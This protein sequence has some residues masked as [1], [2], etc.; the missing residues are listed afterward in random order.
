MLRERY[1]EDKF[2]MTIQTLASEMDPELAQI[3]RLLDDDEMFRM[4]KQ[5]FAQRHPQTVCTG[6]PS[7]PV[8]VV[9]RMLVVR[10]LYNWSYEDTEHHVK[11][12]LVL[13]RFCRVY[14]E[15]VPDDTTLI[16]W[17]NQIQ[18]DTV[19][20]L[21]ARL[22]T[23]A[24]QLKVTRGRKLRTDGTAVE[25]NIHAPTDNALLADGVRV[26]SRALKRA[27]ALLPAWPASRFRDR[28][29]S[30]KQIARQISQAA[31]QGK[32][33]LKTSFRRLVRLTQASLRQA[34]QVYTALQT[35]PAPAARRLQQTLETI[36]PRLE[37]V[38]EQTQ[39]RVFVGE[40]VPAAEKLVSLFEA[41]S[42]IIKRSSAQQDVVFGHKVW[43]DEVDGG[44]VSG[45]RVLAGNPA[46]CDQ[47]QPSLDHHL[48]QFGHPPHQASADRGLF[49]FPNETYATQLGV[50]HVILP[51]PGSKSDDR[52]RHERQ[53]WFRRGR[54]WH[55]GVEGRISVLKRKHGLDRCLDHGLVGFQRWVGWSVVANNLT[56]MGRQLASA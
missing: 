10:R 31:Y 19:C 16:R 13:R 5:D 33:V 41:H 25:T 17:A 21:N 51:K 4:I 20:A 37:Q 9:L 14:L 50:R 22:T 46:D 8:E 39:R 55:A 23:L 2:F 48:D 18:P 47:W 11:D 26:V 43:L 52:C 30:A 1:D 7:T 53:A 40:T 45:Y 38:L 56:V 28:T 29:R 35:L 3:D 6:R 27:R 32:E 24:T 15:A 54:H 42:A 34:R 49:S 44:I 36:L 12:S